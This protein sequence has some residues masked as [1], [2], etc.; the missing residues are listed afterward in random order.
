MIRRTNVVWDETA[1]EL[2]RETMK[3]GISSVLSQTL[4]GNAEYQFTVTSMMSCSYFVVQLPSP[5]IKQEYGH[6]INDKAYACYWRVPIERRRAVQL[7]PARANL[8]F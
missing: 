7:G 5:L 1:D 2:T 8:P 6:T 4:L 3:F